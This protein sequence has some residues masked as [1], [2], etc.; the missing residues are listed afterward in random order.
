MAEDWSAYSSS[1]HKHNKDSGEAQAR[2]DAEA[3]R[4]NR[5]NGAPGI[6]LQDD[7]D[8]EISEDQKLESEMMRAQGN[9][10]SYMV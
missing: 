4:E 9:Q 6:N 5:R 2:A 7:S 8:D 10:V 3:G 1:L